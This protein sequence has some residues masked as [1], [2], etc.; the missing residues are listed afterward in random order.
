M[1]RNLV[2]VALLLASALIAFAG[3]APP[4]REAMAGVVNGLL[5]RNPRAAVDNVY[6]GSET[7]LA[8]HRDKADFRNSLHNKGLKHVSDDKF[9][10]KVKDGIIA[11][12]DRNG[13]DDFK[14]GL[15][16]N[17]IASVFDKYKPNAPVLGY[18]AGK[19][20]TVTIAGVEF[21]VGFT[22]GG[23]GDYKQRYVLR[24]PV[25]D[26]A[27]G[28]SADYY[29]SPVQFNEA[30]KSYVLY[31]DTYWWSADGSPKIKGPM[32]A[33]DAAK[34]GKSFNKDCMGCH[35]TVFE[36]W[37]DENGEWNSRSESPVY[38]PAGSPHQLDFNGNGPEMYNI[39][40]ERCHGAGSRHIINMGDPKMIIQPERDFTA[41]QQNE[42]CGSCHSRG[43][44][45]DGLHEY[46]LSAE[47]RGYASSLGEPMLGKFLLDKPG[48]WPDGRTSRQH[49]QQMQDLMK[50]SKWE[51]AYHKVTCGECH[52]VHNAQSGHIRK[53]MVVGP[54]GGGA[55]ITLKVK[56]EDNTLCL[57]CHAG[58]G[59]FASLKRQ[60]LLNLK[61]NQD[62]IADAVTAHSKHPYNPSGVL[63]LGRC[64][65]C[66]M[67][68]MAAS[69]DPY[70]MHSHTFEVVSPEKT[71][72]FQAQ[73]GMPNSCAVRCHRAL[74]PAYGQPAD[75]SLTTWTEASDVAVANWLKM[76]YGKSG[77]WW[78]H[79]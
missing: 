54:T 2:V 7:C 61:A 38:A 42:L 73:G 79:Q 33:A 64:T 55:N 28:Y 29:Y 25:T 43:T 72:Q 76:Y 16:F 70:D 63:G 11:D 35:S 77:A 78:K 45:V 46:P 41:K 56:S 48:L 4:S 36:V 6:V 65:E 40:C 1:K 75:L 24:F 34:V 62:A 10:M 74:A 49:H 26:R 9:S 27:S 58:F 52:D 59:P 18:K 53:E 68:R 30:S 21:V 3:T 69:G 37:K 60:D 17:R 32:P 71:L 51:Y 57:A 5:E 50:S 13:V 47:N 22:H 23:T 19:G 66:H 20:Y 31:S 39:G 15:D 8:C 67:A 44:S 14:Q 12:Y